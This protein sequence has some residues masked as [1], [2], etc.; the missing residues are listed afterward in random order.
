[1]NRRRA[2]LALMVAP[3]LVGITLLVVIPAL[4]TFG[5]AFTDDDLIRAPNLIGADNFTALAHDNVFWI[6]LRNSLVYAFVAT[7]LRLAGALGMALLLHR[8]RRGNG[9]ART[10]TYL[11]SV[12]PDVAYAL[13]WLW[14]FNPLYGPINLVLGSLH[15]PKPR[16]FSDPQ[17]AMAVVIIM[18][19]FQIGEGFLVLLSLIHI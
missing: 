13:L 2:H 11:P 4:I 9:A 5:I 8:R 6:S 19:L 12:V 18:S 10:A 14:L 16:W 17:P 7:P 1:M 3:Y 15:V